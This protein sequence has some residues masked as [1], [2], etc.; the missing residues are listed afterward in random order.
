MAERTYKDAVTALN[1]LQTNHA[2]LAAIRQSG[3]RLN[4]QAI[5]EMREWVSRV[6][7]TPSEFDRLNI[8]HVAGTKGKGSVCVC[9]SHLLTQYTQHLPPGRQRVGLYTSPH[10]RSVRERIRID[11]VPI[12]EGLFAK[13]FFE[14]WDI[15]EKTARERGVDPGTKPVYFRYLTL[16]AFHVFLREGVGAVVLEVGIGGE[17]DST[18]IIEKPVTVGVSRLGIDHVAVLGETLEKI[19][20]HKAGVVK[21]GVRAFSVEQMEEAKNVLEGRAVELGALGGKFEW[22]GQEVIPEGTELGLQGGFQRGNA[23]LGVA[24]AAE[25]LR[26]VTDGKVD[27]E[28]DYLRRKELPQGFKEGLRKTRWPGRC[29]VVPDPKLGEDRL[30]WCLDGAHTVDS[31]EVAGAWFAERERERERDPGTSTSSTPSPRSR[32]RKRILIFN[33]QTRDAPGLLKALHRK[34]ATSFQ[35]H[36]VSPPQAIFSH[37][38]FTTNLTFTSTGY[39]PD[40]VATHGTNPDDVSQLVVQKR[41]DSEWAVLDSDCAD[42]GAKRLVCASIEEAVETVRGVVGTGEGEQEETVVVLVTGSLH[43]VGGVLEVL[44]VREEGDVE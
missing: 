40:L 8:I 5:P 22:V 27:V 10:M 31:L 11:N 9:V 26:V 29:Q 2:I 12:S 17:Y 23:A 15:L 39:K 6:G 24:L 25:A 42:G 3:G 37:V 16:M 18:N 19:A 28:Q 1:T 41:L 33:Q 21:K 7:Y 32:P 35:H 34:L 38:I 36:L 30:E 43:L 4:S 44:D 14:V 13:Y 20:W